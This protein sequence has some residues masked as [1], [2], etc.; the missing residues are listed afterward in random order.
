MSK[1][2]SKP[3]CLVTVPAMAAAFAAPA[4]S[5]TIASVSAIGTTPVGGEVQIDSVTIGT[6]TLAIV[7]G[8]TV[9]A[10]GAGNPGADTILSASGLFSGSSTTAADAAGIL[11]DNLVSTGVSGSTVGTDF[12]FSRDL[13]ADDVI[14]YFEVSTNAST[15]N[16]EVLLI[17]ASGASFGS[18]LN[19]TSFIGDTGARFAAST[20]STS[21]S[22]GNF[23]SPADDRVLGVSFTLE[24][25]GYDPGTDPAARGITIGQNGGTDPTFV[26][27]VAIPEPSSLALAG[28]GSLLVLGRRRRG[29]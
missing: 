1:T 4:M 5:A 14:V 6:D 19:L 29:G 25:F 9:P 28:I 24:D 8:A 13:N 11:S 23:G 27:L 26:G 7:E 22:V 10:S 16:V 2:L 21:G 12:F 15:E 20:T 17:D 3:F 18:A